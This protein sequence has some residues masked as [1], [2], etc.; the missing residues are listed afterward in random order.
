MDDF[1]GFQLTD[2]HS[3]DGEEAKEGG[4][5]TNPS[6]RNELHPSTAGEMDQSRPAEQRGGDL[7]RVQE[8]DAGR[9]REEREDKVVDAVEM[10]DEGDDEEEEE[11][12]EGEVLSTDTAI[13]G[14]ELEV[15]C[16]YL[17]CLS[18]KHIHTTYRRNNRE[19]F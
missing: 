12:K 9:E 7:G 15:Q 10:E 2:R 14:T 8:E 6:V 19:S 1:D 4:V 11:L 16:F 13:S 17:R 3:S 18:T 5:D